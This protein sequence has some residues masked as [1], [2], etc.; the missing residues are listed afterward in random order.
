MTTRANQTSLA[1]TARRIEAG[2]L[3][4][5]AF[6]LALI[7]AIK[8]REAEV[9]AWQWFEA[10]R[11]L[12]LAREADAGGERGA[13]HGIPIGIKDIIA[14]R[15]IPTEVGSPAFAGR[16]PSEDATVV[17]KLRA[18]GAFVMG[19]TVTTEFAFRKPGKTRNPWNTAH[20]P[21]GSSSGSAAAVA[22]GFVPAALGSQT[23]GSII[24]PAAF[25]GVVGFKPSYGL[26]SRAGV[27]PFAASLDHIGTFTRSVADAAWLAA[28]LTGYDA[29]DAASLAAPQAIAPVIVPLARAPRLALVKT[30]NWDAAE[31]AQQAS[32][33]AC[34][35][36]LREAGAQVVEL[37]LPAPFARAQDTVQT[38]MR[39]E[40]AQ[41][42]RPI[43]AAHP[44]KV[45]EHIAEV[46]ETGQQFSA[47]QYLDAL[48]N[49]R[50]VREGIA[51]LLRGVDAIITA[52]APGEAPEGLGF[53]GNPVFCS[54]WSLAGVP[55]VTIPV[56]RGPRGL[57]LG[58]QIVGKSL[59]DMT[60]LS[61]AEWCERHLPPFEGL[62]EAG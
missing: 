43:K 32:L 24:R 27:F 36:A 3:K 37:D 34:A 61:V 1:E 26:I 55:A 15:G 10:E 28:Q 56:A 60:V 16:V 59:D 45:S 58:L 39:C 47:A 4:S 49:G 38:V 51:Q 40:A 50:A 48:A 12:R 20:T 2:E 41:V 14:T 30:P 6:T 53:T 19:K 31:A 29:A 42:F 57:P 9:G 11:A 5:E 44:D 35:Q 7:E 8:R 62:R 13:L 17:Q 52:P 18:A 25:C 23:L 21:G 22:A 46:I 33:L 54:T